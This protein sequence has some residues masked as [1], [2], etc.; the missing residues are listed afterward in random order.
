MKKIFCGMFTL[1]C[2]LAL[3]TGK[4]SAQANEYAIPAS[5]TIGNSYQGTAR[6]TNAPLGVT[7]KVFTNFN[8]SSKNA[9]DVKWSSNATSTLV[10]YRE[11]GVEMRS[12]YNEKGNLDYTISY[13][14]DKQI[15]S[16]YTSLARREGY[17]QKIILV[18]E[19]NR[20]NAKTA[21]IKM[22]DESSIITIAVTPSGEVINHETL[23]KGK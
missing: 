14:R 23:S 5:S 2:I 6:F 4:V 9:T 13:F 8:A 7:N 12:R 20:K 22:E 1:S 18:S 10:H 15:P 19:V 21:F 3:S 17:I 11:N 16:K